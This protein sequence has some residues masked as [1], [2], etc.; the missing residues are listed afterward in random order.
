[1]SLSFPL[2]AAIPADVP[3][4]PKPSPSY[5]ISSS[6]TLKLT[7]FAAFLMSLAPNLSFQA[8]ARLPPL[9]FFTSPPG[10]ARGLAV[11]AGG[12]SCHFSI[13]LTISSCMLRPVDPLGS[14]PKASTRAISVHLPATKR[15]ARMR[16]GGGVLR[17]MMSHW[18]MKPTCKSPALTAVALDMPAADF[19]F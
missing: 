5:P 17:W 18:L 4:V 16:S 19:L 3:S 6:A 9:R 1:M 13:F 7:L 8:R 10:I 11:L 14:S 2:A 12:G 15:A